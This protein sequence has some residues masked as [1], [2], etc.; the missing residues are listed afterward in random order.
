MRIQALSL[1][2]ALAAYSVAA[3][4]A[5]AAIHHERQLAPPARPTPV[6]TIQLVDSRP[7]AAPTPSLTLPLSVN[8][9]PQIESSI[10]FLLA[11]VTWGASADPASPEPA[12]QPDVPVT[13]GLLAVF[14]A[15]AVAHTVQCHRTRRLRMPHLRPALAGLV[16]A[17]CL[18]RVAACG[19]RIAW[20]RTPG[21]WDLMLA[22][23]VLLNVG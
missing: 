16:L 5:T 20:A 15:G 8:T 17:F 23:G 4:A 2:T 11:A 10:P 14:A 12:A 7:T 22:V 21:N 18:L 6:S 1:A 13:A 19:V 9:D 3:Q